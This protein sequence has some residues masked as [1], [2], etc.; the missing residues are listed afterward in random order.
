MPDAQRRRLSLLLASLALAGLGCWGAPRNEYDS[1]RAHAA[2]EAAL[3]AWKAGQ[4]AALKSRTP[5]I[6]F[7]DDDL[8]AG[9]KLQEYLLL[10]PLE[11][12]LP[13]QGIPVTLTLQSRTGKPVTR[14]ALYQVSFAAEATAVLR[15]DP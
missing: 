14:R 12:I 13:L 15:S 6:R 7:V 1:Q 10:E 11:R 2:L 3:E 8:S 5:P 9:F 4:L